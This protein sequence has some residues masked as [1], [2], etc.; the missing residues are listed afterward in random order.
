V[1][2]TAAQPYW[3]PSSFWHHSSDT[4]EWCISSATRTKKL[5]CHARFI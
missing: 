3:L 2:Y 4:V 1:T 5:W